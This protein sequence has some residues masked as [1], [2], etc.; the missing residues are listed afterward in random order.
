VDWF[1]LTRVRVQLQVA[2]STAVN[3][4]V[5][6]E[7]SV[8]TRTQTHCKLNTF[9]FSDVIFVILYIESILYQ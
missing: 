1:Q 4:R 2:A 5:S 7:S 6:S 9:T 3:G 8:E